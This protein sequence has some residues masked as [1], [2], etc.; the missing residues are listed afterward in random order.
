MALVVGRRRVLT[1]LMFFVESAWGL[2]ILLS[3]KPECFVLE[4]PVDT[5]LTMYYEIPALEKLVLPLKEEDAPSKAMKVSLVDR[6]SGKMVFS[7][8]V[9]DH[10]GEVSLT[11][12]SG[13]QHRLC[14]EPTRP[15]SSPL[16]VDLS[17]E[18]GQGDRYYDELANA[19]KMDKLQLEVVKLNDELAQILSEADYM[20]EKEVKFHRKAERFNLVS[21]LFVSFKVLPQAAIWW[22]ILQLGILVFTAIF[23]VNNL[24]RFFASKNLY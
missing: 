21:S 22:P 15:Q 23:Q 11:T 2:F 10:K 3:D 24:K 7:K 4:H 12:N 5:T 1:V 9:G 6:R 14:L 8:T 19:N 13:S 20:K 18:L 16:R 17:L